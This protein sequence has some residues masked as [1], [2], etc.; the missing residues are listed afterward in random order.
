MYNRDCSAIAQHAC[1]SPDGLVD[2]IE[3]TLCSIQAGLST[4]KMQ[5]KDIAANGLDSIY[6][7]GAKRDGLAYARE[8]KAYLWSKLMSI[9]E[10]GLSDASAIADA[11]L[12]LM[13]VPCLGL[14]KAAFV[15]QMLGFDVACLD[16]HNL[17]RKGINLNRVKVGAKLSKELKRKKVLDYIQLCNDTNDA[18]QGESCSEYY[19]NS[20]C[21]YVA[22][23]KA[24]KLLDTA[25][26]VSKYHYDAIVGV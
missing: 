24:N 9:R 18:V 7:W 10:D 1:A 22:G 4:I 16:S 8:N 11:L 15:A 17:R 21:D 20:W 14:V 26:V 23:N 12:L 13:K 19:W 5:R 25:D 3:F 6:L 2:V